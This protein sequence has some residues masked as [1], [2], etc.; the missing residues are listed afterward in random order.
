MDAGTIVVRLVVSGLLLLMD[1]EAARTLTV[2]A[3]AVAPDGQFASHAVWL[4]Y[5]RA[6]SSGTCPESAVDTSSFSKKGDGRLCWHRVEGMRIEIQGIRAVEAEDVEIGDGMRDFRSIEHVLPLGRSVEGVV[7]C[8]KGK[9]SD[10]VMSR[11][12]GFVYHER[13]SCGITGELRRFDLGEEWHY[14]NQQFD[15]GGPRSLANIGVYEIRAAGDSR[16]ILTLEDGEGIQSEIELKPTSQ[17]AVEILFTNSPYEIAKKVP[18]GSGHETGV[19][20]HLAVYSGIATV[21]FQE[22]SGAEGWGPEIFRRFI[23]EKD[24]PDPCTSALLAGTCSALPYHNCSNAPMKT[25]ADPDGPPLC[26]CGRVV[27]QSQ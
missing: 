1:E 20:H 9:D 14:Y 7:D 8:D 15:I 6:S 16:V 25:S 27:L 11:L 13:W 23:V 10:C 18:D 22:L 19:A 12:S 26:P 21:E 3:P 4:A 5:P 2:A 24:S 17:M